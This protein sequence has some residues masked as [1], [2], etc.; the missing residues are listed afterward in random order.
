MKKRIMTIALCLCLLAVA[1]MG[2][3]AYFTDTESAKNVFTVGNVDITQNEQ[4]IKDRQIV[5]F[6][7]GSRLLP[8]GDDEA[9]GETV[10]ELNGSK[11]KVFESDNALSKIVSV[12][13]NGNSPAYVRTI[14]ALEGNKDNW[15]KNI[16]L[17][18]S[19]NPYGD[20]D[21]IEEDNDLIVEIN[22]QDY[23]I[24]IY[25]YK[26]A[27][28]A[29][30]TSKPSITGVGLYCETTK[31]DIAAFG[32]EYEVL[33]ISQAVQADDMGDDAGAALDKA[34]GVVNE[35]NVQAWFKDVA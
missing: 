32:S 22:D 28:E 21:L 3:I 16:A 24:V 8:M 20:P 34:F 23:I 11:F 31:E 17:S 13:N 12:T 4:M 26:N 18:T 10:Y 25:T 19:K 7:G 1:A 30:Q 15:Y 35:E 33:V 9:W 14:V 29:K 5:T 27:L 6:E 2:T